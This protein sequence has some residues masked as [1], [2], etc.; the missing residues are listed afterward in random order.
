M[1]TCA[2]ARHATA[3][4]PCEA[5]I[6]LRRG[7]RATCQARIRDGPAAPPRAAPDP[8]KHGGPLEHRLRDSRV[9]KSARETMRAVGNMAQSGDGPHGARAPKTSLQRP[10]EQPP[11]RPG[12]ADGWRI[13]TARSARKNR[14]LQTLPDGVR[15]G[16]SV[17][18]AW[19]AT[20]GGGECSAADLQC[21]CDV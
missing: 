2:R 21:A 6:F 17:G 1:L 12:M 7:P 14:R 8:P 20:R 3:P 15:S 19:F 18:Q 5:L 10:P 16:V 13:G 11:L 9:D 4:R